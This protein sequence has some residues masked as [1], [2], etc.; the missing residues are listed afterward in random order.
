[1]RTV[2]LI[3]GLAFSAAL[4]S[5]CGCF[6]IEKTPGCSGSSP[7]GMTPEVPSFKEGGKGWR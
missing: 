2:L 1:M 4:L 6:D 7:Y 5:G 3:I